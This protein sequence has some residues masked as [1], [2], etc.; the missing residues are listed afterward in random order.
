MNF[1]VQ[2]VNIE[3]SRISVAHRHTYKYSRTALMTKLNLWKPRLTR[4][5]IE[6][7]T[8]VVQNSDGGYVLEFSVI[9]DYNKPEDYMF[10]YSNKHDRDIDY[11]KLMNLCS[12]ISLINGDIIS[13]VDLQ[14]I[15]KANQT[16]ASL[17]F[18]LKYWKN[19]SRKIVKRLTW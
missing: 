1:T 9:I 19:I 15:A 10:V 7:L 2:G 12:T 18:S 17:T 13:K 4:K 5:S 6:H 3:C 11:F 16:Y 8:R 14:G